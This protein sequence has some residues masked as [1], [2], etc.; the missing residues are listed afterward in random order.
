MNINSPKAYFD[1]LRQVVAQHSLQFELVEN[2]EW[3]REGGL[4]TRAKA[5][6]HRL[7]STSLHSPTCMLAHKL[8]ATEYLVCSE[9][10]GKALG[11][12]YRLWQEVKAAEQGYACAREDFR[13]AMLEVCGLA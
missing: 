5:I 7:P 4:I 3:V 11:M 2:C 10:A 9:Y 13:A 6:Y 1:A 12:P 8:G